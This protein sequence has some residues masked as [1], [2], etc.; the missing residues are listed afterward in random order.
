MKKHSINPN[1]FYEM[2]LQINFMK[3][4]FLE[5]IPRRWKTKGLITIYMIYDD[6]NINCKK[7]WMG[8]NLSYL[9][10]KSYGNK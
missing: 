1:K 6:H 8:L 9:L 5:S 10:K 7:S 3:C 4:D 2:G